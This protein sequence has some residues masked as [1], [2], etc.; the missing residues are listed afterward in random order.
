MRERRSCGNWARFLQIGRRVSSLNTR[1]LIGSIAA[2]T[3]LM[4][5]R[6]SL[7]HAQTSPPTTQATQ[8]A[9]QSA[10]AGPT[11]VSP[12]LTGRPVTGIRITGNNHV[13]TAVILN[14]I[15]TRQGQPFDPATVEE[16]Y[17]RVY[18][19][20][21]FTNVEAR[22]EPTPDGGVIVS[23]T[24]SE[25]QQ[26]GQIKF[27]GISAGEDAALRDLIDVK[28][29]EA[30]DHF[31]INI[32]RDAIENYYRDKNYPFVHVAIGDDTLNQ[33]GIVY[34]HITLGP[35]VKV[36]KIKFI[37]NKS[38]S[39]ERLDG[40]V[41]TASWIFVL[42]PGTFRPET[43][44]QD[45]AALQRFYQ[46]HG[47]FDVR[48]GR[49]LV[50]SPDQQSLMVEFLIDEGVRYTIDH[51]SFKGNGS[52]DDATLRQHLKLTEGL[53]FDTDALQRD[54]RE[55]VRAYSPYGFI[56]DPEGRN[57]DYLHINPRTVFHKEAGKVEIV[58]DIS[59]GQRFK[60]GRIVVKGNW[61]TQDKVILREI[62]VV[63]GQTY[64]SGE[65]ADATDRL[66]G[67]PYFANINMTPIGD[68]P[69][70]RDLLVEVTEGKTANFSI[71]AGVSSNGGVGGNLSFEQRNFDLGN[72]P[73]RFSD[74]LDDR[75]FTG[76]GQNFRISLEPGTEQ[77]NASIR[78]SEPYLFD[79]P[80]SFSGELYLR[81]RQ[82]DV[83][84]DNRLGGT[85]TLGKRFNYVYSASLSI[86]GEQVH[87]DHIDDPVLRAP[88]IFDS[89]GY[90]LLT[91]VGPHFRRDTTNR[92]PLA[93]KGSVVNLG[94]DFYG[95]LG[96]DYHYQ[97]AALSWDRYLTLN[98]DLLDRRTVLAL[99]A[100]TGYIFGN[101]PFFE[102]YYGGGIGSVRGFDY[103]GISPREGLEDDAIGG[104]FVLTGTAELSFP[105]AGEML[106]G[107]VFTDAGTVEQS[108]EINTI[109]TSAGFGF[110]LTLPML[111]QT[112]LAVDFA[113][114]ITRD[115]QDETQYISF[116]FGFIQ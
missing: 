34:F 4:L 109:R 89:Q 54:V 104:N 72:V 110:R 68:D 29:G 47:F 8:N 112:P 116:S 84:D 66:R 20:K 52:V 13:S 19:L 98:Q 100:D 91:S 103:R 37:G 10:P 65:I 114:P 1:R 70:V 95:A 115:D 113:V 7:A 108:M 5:L 57:P 6:P 24:V 9:V 46:E 107:V 32:A 56:Y 86:R 16:D 11:I 44:E 62:R 67:T 60:L 105:L 35:N 42:R 31:R 93:Y 55:I 76:A 87:I 39:S 63:P 43:V 97:K 18:D 71:G 3:A 58:Y 14:L 81:D 101:A 94:I 33:D 75:A 64:N 28:P 78:F 111:G 73:D 27:T 88:E 106:R 59:E 82:R 22:V 99:H 17:R 102:R 50:F 21:K 92:G 49:K 90:S 41:K 23:F 12:E 2:T 83:Y 74:F 80:Y 85:V 77:T 15:R 51:V 45:V 40:Q 53:Y 96:G 38:F 48:I 36:R 30:I 26:I 79:Q 25:P 69:N 61:K